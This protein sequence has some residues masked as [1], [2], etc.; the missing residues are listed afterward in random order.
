MS[1]IEGV[2]KETSDELLCEFSA[3]FRT[4]GG[5]NQDGDQFIRK[6]L[7]SVM[8]VDQALEVISQLDEEKHKIPFKHL[9]DIDPKL[10][11]GFIKGEHP[12]TISIIISHLGHQK[13]SQVLGFLPEQLQYEIVTRIA[14]L[15]IGTSRPDP[16]SGRSARKRADLHRQPGAS[17]SAASGLSL[18]SSTTATAE[19]ETTFC[20]SSMKPTPIWLRKS[21]S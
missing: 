20:S 14:N 6:L 12:Q 5:V 1:A 21:E 8:K 15:E 17:R 19:R 9:R 3:R 4:E 13:A 18:K 16:G 11:A 10:L 2:K 7:P